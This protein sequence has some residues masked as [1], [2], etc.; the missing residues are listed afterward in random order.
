ME[1]NSKVY[2]AGHN[3]LVGSGIVRELE[4]QGYTNILTRTHQELDLLDTQKVKE[5]FKQEKPDYIFLAAAKVGGILA[6]NNF[7]ADFIFENLQVQ[8]N[9]IHNAYL[10]KVKKLL[11]L[12][13]SCIYP[14][15]CP[16]P[17]KEKYI[18]TKELEPTN[19]PYAIAK[20]AGIKM[21]QSYNRQHGTCFISVMPT[22]LYG[23]NDNF[24]PERGHVIPALINKIYKAKTS[25]TKSIT[26][27]GTGTPKREFLFVDDLANACVYLMQN[28]ND[29]EIINIGTGEDITIKE[30][31]ETICKVINYKG[32]LEFDTTKP[33]GTPRKLLDVTKI[34][35]LGWK[36]KTSLE[37]GLRKTYNWYLK[38]TNVRS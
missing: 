8:N 31:A 2:V 30:L 32:D 9:V 19:E 15:H 33:D 6:N 13:S 23:I 1:K 18:L 21:C 4:L 11:F 17:I 36:A 37:E 14:K 29:S 22:N 28:Y 20:I 25:G 35:T 7:P 16:Q 34:N 24:N 27:W 10:N 26:I 3:G 12:G 5:F 38:S